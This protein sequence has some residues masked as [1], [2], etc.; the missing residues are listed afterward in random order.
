MS[1]LAGLGIDRR[2]VSVSLTRKAAGSFNA[3]GDAVPGAATTSTILAVVQPASG[4]QLMDL[5]EGIRTEARWLAWSRA[6]IRL[7]DVI[8]H[9]GRSYRAMYLWP[10]ADGAFY[11]A[12]MGELAP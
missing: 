12:A 7:D 10:R 5:P 2:S 11:R 1:A 4:R 6:E 3:D 8:T 9:G